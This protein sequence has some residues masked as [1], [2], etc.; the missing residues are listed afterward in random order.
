MLKSSIIRTFII[1]Y[2]LYKRIKVCW[3]TSFCQF[4]QNCYQGSEFKTVDVKSDVDFDDI[5]H[6]WYQK[7]NQPEKRNGQR[8]PLEK[9]WAISGF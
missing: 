4:L 5:F 9:F 8:T 3:I 7:N 6:V 2:L 1:P